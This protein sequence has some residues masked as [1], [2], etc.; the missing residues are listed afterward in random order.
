MEGPGGSPAGGGG[1]G[2]AG[3]QVEQL[4]GATV[5]SEMSQRAPTPPPPPDHQVI[6][7]AHRVGKPPER[8]KSSLMNTIS[9]TLNV[10]LLLIALTRD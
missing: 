7:A 6:S 2:E 9:S 8:E 1:R 4:G 3:N 5:K 10:Q